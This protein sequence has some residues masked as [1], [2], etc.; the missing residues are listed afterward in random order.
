MRRRFFRAFPAALAAILLLGRPSAR[1]AAVSA[2]A[3]IQVGAYAPLSGSEAG[4]GR[5][6]ERGTRLAL[7]ELN[8]AGGALGRPLQ[9]RLEDNRSQAGE[10]A[11]LVRRLLDRDKV[12]AVLGDVSSA[13]SLEAAPVC[14]E[15]RVPMISHGSNP[16][17]TDIG[18]YIFRVAGPESIQGR[19]MAQFAYDDLKANRVAVLVDE[20]NASSALLAKAFRDRFLSQGGVVASEQRYAGGDK[21]FHEQLAALTS[22]GLDALFVPGAQPDVGLIIEQ[23]RATGFTGPILGGEGWAVPTGSPVNA[24]ALRNTYY[25]DRYW[26]EPDSPLTQRF[27]AHYREKFHEEPDS[28]ASLSYDAVVLLADAIARAGTTNARKLRD[29]LAATRDFAGVSGRLTVDAQR[30]PQKPA[31]VVGYRDGRYRRIKT[32]SP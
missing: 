3:P 16:Q 32:L 15:R 7:E 17:V 28:I 30:N 19:A 21:D 20:T 13:R 14:Q 1:L 31:H 22:G 10:S 11:Q 23:A 25:C 29:A 2:P 4:G 27:I 5:S 18:D 9:L 26:L 8:A 12:I 6:F 24:D